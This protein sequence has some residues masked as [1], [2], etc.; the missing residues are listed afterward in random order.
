[1]HISIGKLKHNRNVAAHACGKK[2]LRYNRHSGTE[3]N[4]EPPID[5]EPRHPHSKQAAP[6]QALAEAAS[7]YPESSPNSSPSDPEVLRRLFANMLTC[8]LVR[9]RARAL[10]DHQPGSHAG[11]TVTGAEAIEAGATFELRAE[12][13]LSLGHRHE[14]AQVLKGRPLKQIFAQMLGAPERPMRPPAADPFVASNII[15]TAS[16][17]AAQFNLVAG[18][19]F[20]YKQRAQRNVVLAIFSDGFDSLGSWHEAA[21]LAGE[22]RLPVIFV[23]ESDHRRHN[24]SNHWFGQPGD[25]SER[26]HEYGFPGIPVDGDDV[27]AVFRVTQESIHRARNGAGPTLIECQSSRSG[28][29]ASTAVNGSRR[30][31]TAGSVDPLAHMEHYLRKR[32]AWSNAWR[33]KVV[34]QITREIDEALAALQTR[35]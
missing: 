5:T 21:K 31:K 24:G 15:P 9:E 34:H 7:K 30:V 32:K 8:R 14:V 29:H 20:A 16:S 28:H 35:R 2:R 22:H 11:W 1:M 4:M 26:A 10:A 12:D 27:V 18:V 6:E 25:L 3:R 19:A 13:A 17:V 33:E 23:V